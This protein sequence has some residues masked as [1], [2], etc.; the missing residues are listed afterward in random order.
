MLFR[1]YREKMK[2]F[3][4]AYKNQNNA[5]EHNDPAFIINMKLKL[6]NDDINLIQAGKRSFLQLQTK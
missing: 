4:L 6:Q 2:K 3:Y 1:N 5:E